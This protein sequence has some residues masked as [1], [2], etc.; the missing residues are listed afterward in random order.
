MRK[1]WNSDKLI[2]TRFNESSTSTL[3]VR[4][5]AGFW[6]WSGLPRPNNASAN[7]RTWQSDLQHFVSST[8]YAASQTPDLGIDLQQSRPNAQLETN[9]RYLTRLKATEMKGKTHPA[10][11]LIHS[12]TR[13]AVV[14]IAVERSVWLRPP[15][16]RRQT[17]LARDNNKSASKNRYDDSAHFQ[18][19]TNQTTAPDNSRFHCSF[20]NNAAKPLSVLLH[21]SGTFDA[22]HSTTT[23]LSVTKYY[24]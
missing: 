7:Y 12:H 1:T 4:W 11:S 18:Q 22:L 9:L 16:G 14:I 15:N 6:I 3:R 17:S 13:N 19:P 5:K 21:R 23:V 2:R 24:S 8:C 20:K 10:H